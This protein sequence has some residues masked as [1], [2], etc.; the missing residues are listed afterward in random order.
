M[1]FTRLTLW[2]AFAS[3]R[4]E[5]PGQGR[6]ETGVDLGLATRLMRSIAWLTLGSA[7]LAGCA[8]VSVSSS[9]EQKQKVVA[10]RAQARWDVLIKG[11]VP[12]AYEFL[13]SGSRAGTSL[14]LYKAQMKPGMWRQA[15]V[16]R[17]DC[18]AEIC[19]VMLVITYDAKQMR[20]IQTPLAE[21]WIIENGSA[22]YI[23]R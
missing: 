8:T 20:G 13:S 17:V 1:P 15:K 18:E 9:P 21:T 7:V 2:G 19:K 10:E 14:E 4:N 16:E 3:L 23:Y 5:S 6:L 12:S 11:D 22:W